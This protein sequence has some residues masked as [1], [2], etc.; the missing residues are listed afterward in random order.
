VEV[1]GGGGG[2][3]CAALGELVTS[4]VTADV[5]SAMGPTKAADATVVMLLGVTVA[6]AFLAAYFY[7]YDLSAERAKKHALEVRR[8]VTATL[9]LSQDKDA[10]VLL[11]PLISI[12]TAL[13]MASLSK[14]HDQAASPH[15]ESEGLNEAMR[16][17]AWADLGGAGVGGAVLHG[18]AESPGL[19]CGRGLQAG[20]LRQ[21]R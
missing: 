5:E 11:L 8:T 10:V 21:I 18:A 17:R 13:T 12:L 19:P 1:I 4:C 7:L 14:D 2:R 9:S 3:V 6:V 15:S 16:W 20:D